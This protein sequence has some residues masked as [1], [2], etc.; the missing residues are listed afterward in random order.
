MKCGPTLQ[1]PFDS[2]CRVE[3]CFV[4]QKAEQ[5]V[6]AAK[7]VMSDADARLIVRTKAAVKATDDYVHDRPWKAAA[8]AAGL[9][10]GIGF[11]LGRR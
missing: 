4:R 7:K 1:I 8:V 3:S 11:L 10:L 5:S 9:A 6:A 2:K